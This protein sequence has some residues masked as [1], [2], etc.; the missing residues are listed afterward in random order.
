M[1][2]NRCMFANADKDPLGIGQCAVVYHDGYRCLNPSTQGSVWCAPHGDGDLRFEAERLPRAEIV[3]KGTTVP[4]WCHACGMRVA[5]PAHMVIPAF[6]TDPDSE[7]AWQATVGAGVV[8][9]RLA[10]PFCTNPLWPKPTRN[11]T[12]VQV[13]GILP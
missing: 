3:A 13:R 11:P 9:I 5:L 10:C 8:P 12:G 6:A 7:L 2:L 1:R 4:G